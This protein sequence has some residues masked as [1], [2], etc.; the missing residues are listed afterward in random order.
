MSKV[1]YKCDPVY[2]NHDYNYYI[3]IHTVLQ[4]STTFIHISQHPKIQV[5]N[6]DDIA[7]NIKTNRSDIIPIFFFRGEGGMLLFNIKCLNHTQQ[8]Q[9]QST[10]KTFTTTVKF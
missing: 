4:V 7:I 10:H 6:R 3:V 2:Y 5:R 9:H 1:L 8:A